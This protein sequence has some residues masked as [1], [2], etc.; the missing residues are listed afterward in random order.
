M[1]EGTLFA[2]IR[3]ASSKSFFLSK[4]E[5][6][7][8]FSDLYFHRFGLGF[9]WRTA[10]KHGRTVDAAEQAPPHRPAA[11]LF[12]FGANPPYPSDYVDK[13]TLYT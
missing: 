4:S 7:W 6:S 3:C 2:L 8:E 11:L 12:F 5:N 10:A 1:G 13:S 9:S